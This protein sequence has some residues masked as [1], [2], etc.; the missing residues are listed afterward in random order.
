MKKMPLSNST[1][2]RH[3]DE[4]ANDVKH[5]LINILQRSEFFIEVDESAV[6]N[7]Q[8]L[9]MVYVRFFS[10][11]LQPCEEMLFTEKLPLDSKDYISKRQF[12]QFP[13]LDSLK[14]ELI[15]EDLT[16][17]RNYLHDNVVERFQDVITLNSPK[18]YS[19]PFEVDAVDCEDDV[20]EELIELQNDND[21]TMRYRCNGKEGYY[22]SL[23]LDLM[24]D[25]SKSHLIF[26]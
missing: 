2:F 10:D 4:I 8:C 12:H 14:F 26:Y 11:V 9:M 17:Y 7:N 13:L 3:I 22:E 19:N 23:C 6:V 20:R 24:S 21:T 5:Q 15:D 18:W 25:G 1:I 16:T